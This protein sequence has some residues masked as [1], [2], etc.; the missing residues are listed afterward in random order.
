MKI[1]IKEPLVVSQA[2]IGEKRWGYWQFPSLGY[3][4]DSKIAV[5]FNAC[6]DSITGYGSAEPFYVLE[7]NRW[8][9]ADVKTARHGLLLPNGDCISHCVLPSLKVADLKLP[10]PAGTRIGS[11]SGPENPIT[12]YR[13]I[14]LLP[15]LANPRFW[16]C[17]KGTADWVEETVEF[18]EPQGIREAKQGLFA[19]IGGGWFKMKVAP[20]KSLFLAKYGYHLNEQN[21]RETYRRIIF[22]RSIDNGR[23]WKIQGTIPY[24]QPDKERDPLAEIREGFME[25]DFE[26]TSKNELLCFMRTDDGHGMGPMY[27]SR[28]VDSGINWSKP[29][30][31]NNFGVL[32]GVLRLKNNALILSYGRPGVEIRFSEDKGSN[33]TEPQRLVATDYPLAFSIVNL[34]GIDWSK[35]QR[36]FSTAAPIVPE[37][38]QLDSCGYT[39]LL[40]MAENRCLIAYSHFRFPDKDGQ[41]RKTILTREIEVNL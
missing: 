29:L 37:K 30:V 24:L 3:T 25:P 19:L 32:P 11:Y 15:E 28:S 33:W 13:V 8:V 31:F 4:A 7:N 5:S 9:L 21:Q 2:P 1:T 22:M 16:R 17:K 38:R 34:T 14:D 26:F 39:S 6:E 35:P 41:E 23:S 10:E 40:P 36:L 27:V 12:A 18:I 20:D